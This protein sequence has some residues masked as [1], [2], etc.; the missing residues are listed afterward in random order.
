MEYPL[1]EILDRVEVIRNQ[2]TEIYEILRSLIESIEKGETTDRGVIEQ[3]VWD[4][5]NFDELGQNSETFYDYSRLEDRLRLFLKASRPEIAVDI[6][7]RNDRYPFNPRVDMRYRNLFD[8][9][10]K[11]AVLVRAPVGSPLFEYEKQWNSVK[12]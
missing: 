4:L 3:L 12:K 1:E 7:D 8:D 10:G 11:A 2:R 5:R 9:S 6:Y